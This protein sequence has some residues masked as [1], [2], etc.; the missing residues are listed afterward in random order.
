MYVPLASL[1]RNSPT[2]CLTNQSRLLGFT[3]STCFIAV[4]KLALPFALF[5]TCC[6]RVVFD[7]RAPSQLVVVNLDDCYIST[8]Q[9]GDAIPD[10]TGCHP[11]ASK[12]AGTLTFSGLKRPRDKD[13]DPRTTAKEINGMMRYFVK[14]GVLGSGDPGDCQCEPT[15]Y[16][17]TFHTSLLMSVGFTRE[18]NSAQRVRSLYYAAVRKPSRFSNI[19]KR[20]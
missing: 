10:I 3:F 19:L 9:S 11:L 6:F 14:G 15:S 5:L 1:H 18:S 17:G 4:M 2:G 7:F 16:F 8:L 13:R 20:A 12:P